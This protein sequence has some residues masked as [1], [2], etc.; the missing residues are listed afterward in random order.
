MAKPIPV[1]IIKPR[2][3]NLNA[4]T[5]YVPVFTAALN[6]RITATD[7]L[8]FT[9]INKVTLAAAFPFMLK[10]AIAVVPFLMPT[11]KMVILAS[12]R[13]AS[14]AILTNGN[15]PP[16]NSPNRSCI[17]PNFASNCTCFPTSVAPN[18]AFIS[19]TLL[20]ITWASIAARSLSVPNFKT[21]SSASLNVIPTR[22]KADTWPCITL[23]IKL[24]IATASWPVAA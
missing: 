2:N 23:P 4:V 3:A 5:E 19:P 24:P 10:A 13:A 12:A 16:S 1:E 11:I 7:F 17:S 22:V 20:V 8:A 18:C 6:T 15:A 14:V 21:F 9:P